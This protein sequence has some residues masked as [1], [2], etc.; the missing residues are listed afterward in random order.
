MHFQ[1]RFLVMVNTSSLKKTNYPHMGESPQHSAMHACVP[2]HMFQCRHACLSAATHVWVPTSML[3]CRHAFL[4]A[5]MHAWVPLCMLGWRYAGFN[6][7]VQAWVPPLTARSAN[8]C[9]NARK[10]QTT[11]WHNMDSNRSFRVHRVGALS[12][13]SQWPNNSP[14]HHWGSN[15]RSKAWCAIERTAPPRTRLKYALQI[16]MQPNDAMADYRR[17]LP[18]KWDNI[19]QSPTFEKCGDYRV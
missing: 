17:C 12:N 10:T 7:P 2:P 9:Q 3:G 19:L 6:P 16:R 8:T 13:G 18:K 14:L 15:W 11:T 5:A 1:H 4:G